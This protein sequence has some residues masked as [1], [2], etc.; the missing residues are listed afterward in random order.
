MPPGQHLTS[1]FPV[2]SAGPTP[3]TQLDRWS[4]ELSNGDNLLA[5]WSW[6]EFGALPQSEI[7]VDIHCVKT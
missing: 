5:E 6:A 1:D 3:E 2:L 4:L 7:T